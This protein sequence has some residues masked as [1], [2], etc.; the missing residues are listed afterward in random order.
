MTVEDFIASE[1]QFSVSNRIANQACCIYLKAHTE[2]KTKNQNK[3]KT[4]NFFILSHYNFFKKKK[5]KDRSS[6][7]SSGCLRTLRDLPASVSRVLGLKTCDPW[8]LSYNFLSTL[9]T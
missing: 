1:A 6:L 7:C 3:Q 8:P 2:A 4:T 9:Y 5:K